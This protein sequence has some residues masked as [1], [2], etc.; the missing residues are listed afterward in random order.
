LVAQGCPRA[1]NGQQTP[2]IVSAQ[3]CGANFALI[4]WLRDLFRE[5]PR[6]GSGASSAPQSAANCATARRASARSS[7]SHGAHDR[8]PHRRAASPGS[9][10]KV[11]FQQ[12]RDGRAAGPGR[13]SCSAIDATFRG[14]SRGDPPA[15]DT[16]RK[17]TALS[18]RHFR[19]PAL[20]IVDPGDVV[21]R[22]PDR[23][24]STRRIRERP[25]PPSP[26]SPP[27]D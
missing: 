2:E 27:D 8:R 9:G 19:Q 24:R 13:D 7:S 26:P 20:R 25:K 15:I 23:L 4:G 11:R 22:H 12:L 5:V 10:R 3:R 21:E 14:I 1:A 18:A 16:G 6:D 17:G